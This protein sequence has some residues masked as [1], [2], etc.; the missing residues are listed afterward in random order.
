MMLSQNHIKFLYVHLL[1]IE[2]LDKGP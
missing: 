2:L 1:C